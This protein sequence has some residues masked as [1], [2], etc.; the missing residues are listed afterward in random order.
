MTSPTIPFEPAAFELGDF[1]L[2][3]E[4]A[5]SLQSIS[6]PVALRRALVTPGASRA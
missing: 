1:Q 6:L 5:Q 2:S 4:A 3:V